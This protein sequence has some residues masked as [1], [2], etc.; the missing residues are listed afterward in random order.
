MS[1]SPKSCNIL[2]I[3]MFLFFFFFDKKTLIL[4]F[5][6]NFIYI[7]VFVSFR[8]L[9]PNI[10]RKTNCIRKLSDNI[11]INIYIIQVS[12]LFMHTNYLYYL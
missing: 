1:C 3:I 10:I 7:D 5:I 2:Y 11:I 6:R 8:L 9:L 12:L 4:L